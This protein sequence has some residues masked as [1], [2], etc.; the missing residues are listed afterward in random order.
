[1]YVHLNEFSERLNKAPRGLDYNQLSFEEKQVAQAMVESGEARFSDC[2]GRTVVV[3][4][5]PNPLLRFITM[6]AYA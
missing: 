1:M 3:H 6:G 2:K 5:T 4:H